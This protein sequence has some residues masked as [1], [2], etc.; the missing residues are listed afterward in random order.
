MHVAATNPLALSDAEVPA[1][2]VA[3]ERAVFEEQVKEDPKMAGKPDNVLKGVVEGRMRKFFE[4]VVLTK[5]KF[6]MAPDQTV[7][8][9]VKAAEKDAGAPIKL[10]G[11][12]RFQLGE[13]VEKPKEDFAAE[14]AGMTGKS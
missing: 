5:Q 6:V 8:A 10:A 3:R 1:E 9:W 13:G 7:E 14:V 2:A 12:R 4:E 11:F